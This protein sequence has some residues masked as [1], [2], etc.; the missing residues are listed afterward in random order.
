MAPVNTKAALP[1]QG[2]DKVCTLLVV[3]LSQSQEGHLCCD[4]HQEE[5]GARLL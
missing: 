1:T 4:H 2:W 5:R 3:I